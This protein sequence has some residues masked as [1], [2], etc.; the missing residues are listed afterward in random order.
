M[1]S[2]KIPFEDYEFGSV[3]KRV[4]NGERPDRP[5]SIGR[6]DPL[7]NVAEL[8]W[9][10]RPETRPSAKD[11]VAKSFWNNRSEIRPSAKDLS[12]FH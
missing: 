2:G 12:F 8:C 6:G 4:T 7:W 9:K 3:V 5:K 10:N 11:I 1:V